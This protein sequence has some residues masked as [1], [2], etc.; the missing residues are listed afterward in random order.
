MSGKVAEESQ[1]AE[2]GVRFQITKWNAVTMWR[3]DIQMDTCA[4]CRNSLSEPSIEYQANPSPNNENGLSIA[5]GS[6][7]HVYHLD[8]VQRWLKSKSTCPLCSNE[9]EGTKFERIP[10]YGTLGS[11]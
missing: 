11:G 5:F 1:Q 6:C 4:I 2:P 10:G 3:W 8:C 7:G 9:W